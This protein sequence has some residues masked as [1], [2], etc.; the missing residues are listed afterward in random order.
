MHS[1]QARQPAFRT[2]AAPGRA[3]LALAL[4]LFG[5][6]PA[7]AATYYVSP[8]G[9]DSNTGTQAAP[10]RTLSKANAT[11]VAGDAC[12]IAAGTYND[13]IQP[14]TNGTATARIS[15]VGNLAS[16]AAVTV[17]SLYI[18]KAYVSVKG[19]RSSGTIELF[20]TS[21]AAKAWHD[22]VAYCI[23]SSGLSFLGA[24]NCLVARSTLNG[25]VAFL[26]DHAYQR[27]G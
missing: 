8:G 5:A 3:L 17:G 15:Y 26:M 22:S 12:M 27:V 10:W 9:S 11:L 6:V 19:V 2:F 13:P 20:Y 25:T 4:I 1:N 16:P 24:K 21:Q 7:A 18:D 14:A 23:S